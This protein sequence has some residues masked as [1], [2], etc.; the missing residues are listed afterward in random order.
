MGGWW[1]G[2]GRGGSKL[3]R[4]RPFLSASSVPGT[5]LFLSR[6]WD[7]PAGPSVKEMLGLLAGYR[8]QKPWVPG[9]QS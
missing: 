1:G 6:Q 3:P 9:A 8:L 5:L 4:E 2:A 7:S